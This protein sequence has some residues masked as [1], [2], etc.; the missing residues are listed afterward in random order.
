M[1]SMV[2][3]A[4]RSGLDTKARGG[5][6]PTSRFRISPTARAWARPLSVSGVSRWPEKRFSRLASV[7]PWREKYSVMPSLSRSFMLSDCDI[8]GVFR[9]H[10]HD[11]IAAIDM[12]AFAGHR[13]TQVGEKIERGIAH[14]LDRHST[15][16][17]SIELVPFQDIAEIAD[18]AGR[19]G[20]DRT[21]RDSVDANGA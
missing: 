10:A 4:R 1:I 20:L 11:M 6:I 18:A 21:G 3:Q 19:Q 12:Q 5:R 14:L 15:A 7:S 8:G 16:Q 9:F 17:G 13:R 2:I